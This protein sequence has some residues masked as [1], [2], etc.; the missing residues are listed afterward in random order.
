MKTFTKN[1]LALQRQEYITAGI[2]FG[3][4][5]RWVNDPAGLVFCDGWYHLFYQTNPES[6]D[7]GNIHW[8]HAV[9]RNLLQ[10]QMCPI[11]IAPHPELGLAFSGS[12][13]VDTENTSGLFPGIS[14]GFVAF[15]TTAKA[16]TDKDGYRQTQSIAF[17]KDRGETW[18][19]YKGNPVIPDYN[20]RDFRDPK[21]FQ[22]K[23]NQRWCAYIANGKKLTLYA[24][25]NLLEWKYLSKYELP[26][27]P[28]VCECPDLIRMEHAGGEFWMLLY[29]ISHDA[30][31]DGAGVRYQMGTFDGTNFIPINPEAPSERCLDL[32]M[33]FYAAQSWYG[34]PDSAQPVIIAWANNSAYSLKLPQALQGANGMMTLPRR[35][36]VRMINGEASVVQTPVLPYNSDFGIAWHSVSCG[37]RCRK[38]SLYEALPFRLEIWDDAC[39]VELL[40]IELCSEDGFSLQLL[41]DMHAGLLSVKRTGLPGI[42][43]CDTIEKFPVDVQ[44]DDRFPA[45]TL[46]VG[47]GLAEMFISGGIAAATYQLFNQ[48]PL[49]LKVMYE[50]DMENI[51]I[52][53]GKIPVRHQVSKSAGIS[54]RESS[55]SK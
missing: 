2:H 31:G 40:Q 44:G 47:A 16:H 3:P 41:V 45:C 24:S 51:D 26:C 38:F 39:A 37:W 22:D 43:S 36:S 54:A 29:S 13:V 53:G 23:K 28:D 18:E 55:S 12:T 21:V 20:M 4:L 34:I 33:D 8:G 50:G 9:S 15:L 52:R 11:A 49:E 48:H 25:E 1:T 32:G 30:D 7:W 19:W 35:L 42:P 46:I 5:D 27:V 10:W 17:S 14:H 6:T